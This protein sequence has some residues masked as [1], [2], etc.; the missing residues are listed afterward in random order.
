MQ[1][2]ILTIVRNTLLPLMLMAVVTPAVEA[3]TTPLQI[4]CASLNGAGT[5][6]NPKWLGSIDRTTKVVW[7]PGLTSGAGFNSRYYAFDLTRSAPASSIIGPAFI[8]TQD[9]QSAVHPRLALPNGFTLLTSLSH[10]QWYSQ[11]PWLLRYLP[12]GGLLAGRY[13][14]GVEKLDSPLRSLQTPSFDIL[15]VL[16]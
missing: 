16:Q 7:C 1:K 14:L 3:Q 8:L 15:I 2:A 12:I 9:A 6:S 11:P 13:W 10:G 4:N 5:F